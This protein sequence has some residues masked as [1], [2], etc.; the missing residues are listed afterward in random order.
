VALA[1]LRRV[2]FV[3]FYGGRRY[4][5]EAHLLALAPSTLHRARPC[6]PTAQVPSPPFV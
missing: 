6:V 5:D 3:M 4:R 2:H 1:Y